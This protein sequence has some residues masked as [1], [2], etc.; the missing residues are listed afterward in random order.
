MVGEMKTNVSFG[1][2][3]EDKT[4]RSLDSHCCEV[5]ASRTS[6]F[7]DAFSLTSKPPWIH[8]CTKH[9]NLSQ[10]LNLIMWFNID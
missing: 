9:F 4:P 8:S 7:P 6:K 5:G 3:L 2:T 1:L 10:G